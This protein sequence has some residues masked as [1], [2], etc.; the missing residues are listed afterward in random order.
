[1]KS[2]IFYSFFILIWTI[3]LLHIHKVISLILKRSCLCVCIMV[4]CNRYKGL[5]DSIL[6]F[7]Y[8]FSQ[9]NFD[10]GL[11]FTKHKQNMNVTSIRQWNWVTF[12]IN[13]YFWISFF[14]YLAT[15]TLTCFSPNT[16]PTFVNVPAI[17]SWNLLMYIEILDLLI[18]HKVGPPPIR[19]P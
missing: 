1:M 13:T 14:I 9:T 19:L 5:I 17:Y 18:G 11:T 16:I 3:K 12:I 8:Y 7:L 6:L 10:I 4:K 15:L 2:A